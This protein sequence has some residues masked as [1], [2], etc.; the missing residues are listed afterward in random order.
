MPVPVIIPHNETIHMQQVVENWKKCNPFI[1]VEMDEEATIKH[2]TFIAERSTNFP[3]SAAELIAIS[4][5][6]LFLH[7]FYF[8]DGY[9]LIVGGRK[10]SV[11]QID[12]MLRFA[13][14]FQQ[15]YTRFLDLQ[16]AE[17]QAREAKIEAALEKVRSR[18]MAMQ[19]SDE[20]P[21]AANVLFLEVQKLGIPAWS[22]GY[23]VL[24]KDKRS[25][26]CWM[27]SEG[28]LQEPFTLR[29]FGEASFDEMGDFLCSEKT[30][31][32]QE[33]AGKAID[34]HYNYMKSFPDLKATFDHIEANGLSLPTFQVNHLCKYTHGFLL[35]ITYE[36]VPDAHDIFKRFTKVFEQTYTRFLDLQKAEAQTREAKIEMALEKVRART[37]GMQKSGELAD[38][39]KVLFTELNSLV[40]NLWTC[41]FV[42]CEKERNEDEWWL[43]MDDGFT[44]GF[45][46][47]NV[48]DFA[49]AS[50]YE[51]WLRGEAFREVQLDGNELQAHYDWLMKV[52]VARAIFEE[53]D[54]AGLAR[55]EW[56]KL[57]LC[58]PP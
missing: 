48:D 3:L 10:L 31:L 40:H 56:Q 7:N 27:S 42:L 53:M 44:R 8:K 11:E 46:L 58:A 50:L 55:P 19:N 49:H 12:I 21:D 41:G 52:P 23:N 20:L 37:M 14:V 30:M 2:Q 18:T 5:A 4:P 26:I 34:D 43:S 24:A 39:A 32:I 45:F 22:C 57:L 36:Q 15:T 51:G 13:T 16:K 54:A 33:L 9:I 1:I 17:A 38:V 35:F 28:A 29:L 25:A 6:K 47:P